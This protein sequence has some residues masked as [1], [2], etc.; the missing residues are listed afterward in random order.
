MNSENISFGKA[1]NHV[2]E[3][4]GNPYSRDC[5]GYVNGKRK[6]TDS[7]PARR[8]LPKIDLDKFNEPEFDFLEWKPLNFVVVPGYYWVCAPG[9]WPQVV[10]F[11][12]VKGFLVPTDSHS[13]DKK[14][15]WKKAAGPIPD[16]VSP[17][18]LKHRTEGRR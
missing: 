2:R 8:K 18:M 16:P 13:A 6:D 12:F 4:E 3:R 1:K 10:K 15:F 14:G 11:E 9:M 5:Y 7:K 17:Y